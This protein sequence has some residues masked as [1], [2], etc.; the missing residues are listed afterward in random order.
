LAINSSKLSKQLHQEKGFLMKKTGNKKSLGTARLKTSRLS[1]IGYFY[2]RL[3]ALRMQ[4][5]LMF[6]RVFRWASMW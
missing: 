2:I 3:M 1:P 4:W 6:L 5:T